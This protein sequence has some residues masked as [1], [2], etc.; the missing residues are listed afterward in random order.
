VA[1]TERGRCLWPRFDA[2]DPADAVVR[3]AL[4][5]ELLGSAGVEAGH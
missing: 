2:A 1:D 3:Q 5:G 4:L